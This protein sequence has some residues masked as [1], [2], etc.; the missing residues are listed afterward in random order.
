MKVQSLS[1]HVPTKGC[2]NS[3][4]M[5]VSRMHKSPHENR[6]TNLSIDLE[7]LFL[8]G[9]LHDDDI[10]DNITAQS[11]Y[12]KR[13]E[14][15]K[16]NGVNT[17]ILTGE[18]E[19]LQ[20]IEFIEWLLYKNDETP[21]FE[22]IELQT[23]GNYLTDKNLRNLK[24]YGVSTISLSVMN[25][26]DSKNNSELISKNHPENIESLEILCERI[27]KYHFNLRL[28]L[29]IWNVYADYTIDEVFK[30]SN[31][32]GADQITFRKLYKSP[33]NNTK[34]DK[35]IDDNTNNLYIE[36][37]WMSPIAPTTQEYFNSLNDFIKEKG[38]FLG[39]LPF[40]ALKYSI[41]G[42]STVVDNNCMSEM[43]IDSD[44]YKYLILRPNCKLYTDWSDK[45]SLL[46]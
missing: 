17:V 35:W 14:F 15:A 45:G 30:K 3:C 34:Q 40:G 23:S 7:K 19:A 13:L 25:I 4:P 5:C 43:D 26:F 8:N 24:K 31:E 6:L 27:K 29:N 41:D 10:Q 38:H 42:I 22:W 36:P 44:V 16:N 33:E 2:V 12:I 20:N 21:K 37:H 46:F 18:G 32:L 1:I 28:S 39:K 9:R 11:D